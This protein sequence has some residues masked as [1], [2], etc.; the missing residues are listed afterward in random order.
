MFYAV[1]PSVHCVRSKIT[2]TINK[3]AK[4]GE[5]TLDS[6]WGLFLYILQPW[7]IPKP[8]GLDHVCENILT[9]STQSNVCPLAMK[10]KCLI[11][12]MIAW[13]SMHGMLWYCIIYVCSYWYKCIITSFCWIIFVMV[14]SISL[15]SC[16][17]QSEQKLS[18]LWD[19]PIFYFW[20][21]NLVQ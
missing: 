6:Q 5:R 18:F 17:S 10:I 21:P 9:I 15:M 14:K 3:V 8:S 2:L 13:Y 20:Q 7:F 16:S 4:V 12:C 19:F 1:Y 11:L